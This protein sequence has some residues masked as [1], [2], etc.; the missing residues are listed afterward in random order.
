[1]LNAEQTIKDATR[2]LYLRKPG[3]LF[4]LLLASHAER[5]LW[6]SFVTLWIL[7]TSQEPKTHLMIVRLHSFSRKY[8]LID[9]PN[10]KN[11]NCSLDGGLAILIKW[12]PLKMIS[13]DRQFSLLVYQF[14]HYQ[15]SW[16]RFSTFRKPLPS[17][18]YHPGK[19][20]SASWFELLEK[21][22]S[23]YIHA[24]GEDVHVLYSPRYNLNRHES[25]SWFGD[26]HKENPKHEDF[27]VCIEQQSLLQLRPWHMRSVRCMTSMWVLS[28]LNL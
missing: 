11:F 25:E 7:A 23:G 27:K 19:L 3:S 24:W 6:S 1:M 14:H 28:D 20:F 10:R 4:R 12:L 16:A 18:T 5:P 8:T 21:F 22:Q 17:Q 9:L 26:F 13:D 15:S 2:I